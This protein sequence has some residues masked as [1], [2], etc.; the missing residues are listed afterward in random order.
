MGVAKRLVVNTASMSVALIFPKFLGLIFLGIA[1]PVLGGR[2]F[3]LY[4]FLISHAVIYCH[5]AALGTDLVVVRNIAQQPKRLGPR[6][7]GPVLLAKWLVVLIL[8]GFMPAFA[9]WGMGLPAEQVRL[10]ALMALY[11]GAAASNDHISSTLQALERMDI[12]AGITVSGSL[13]FFIGATLL[14]W[15]GYR[16]KALIIWF[17]F[18]AV[19]QTIIGIVVVTR[20]FIPFRFRAERGFYGQ[21]FSECWPVTALI[22]LNALYLQVDIQMLGI[23]VGAV[24][25]AYY[26]LA[27]KVLEAVALLPK[28]LTTAVYPLMARL[29]HEDRD[30]LGDLYY[31]YLHLF[32]GL[33]FPPAVAGFIHAEWIMGWFNPDFLP[34]TADCFRLLILVIGIGG[35]ITGPLLIVLLAVDLTKAILPYCVAIVGLNIALNAVLIPRYG[36]SG[37][38]VATLISEVAGC[39][40]QIQFMRRAFNKYPPLLRIYACIMIPSVP[41]AAFL[42]LF[43]SCSPLWTIPVGFIIYGAVI[44]QYGRLP[45]E[46]M[47]PIRN[48]IKKFR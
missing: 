19:V 1:A 6:Y 25:V 20:R 21:L 22:F 43:R 12:R 33:C 39:L 3:G 35:F 5:V 2:D 13:L 46:L 41:M 48:K 10:V 17:V 29:A 15:N 38:C 44:F 4:I 14:L 26:G 18:S 45:E 16:V 30:K 31:K 27:F 47:E 23:M 37:A 36:Y 9:K 24:A 28:A 32:L 7:F 8:A 34:H 42:L 40:M 11:V